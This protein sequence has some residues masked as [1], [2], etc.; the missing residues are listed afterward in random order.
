MIAFG[1]RG[2]VQP[3]VALGKSLKAEGH[4]VRIL[5]GAN[6]KDWI[7]RH[8]LEAVA[9][10]IDIQSLM[11]SDLGRD[12]IEKGANP[13]SQVSILKKLTEQTGW[14]AMIDAWSACR[15]TEVIFSSFTS[16]IYALSIAE[17]LGARHISM[18]LQPALFPTRSG[19][20][21]MNAPL[22]DRT[23]IINYV[24]GKLILEPFNWRLSGKMVNRFRREVLSLEPQTRAQFLAAKRRLFTLQAYSRHIVPHAEDWPSTVRTTGYWFLEEQ[25]EWEPPPDLARFLETG[26]PPV[27]IGF[28]SMIGRNLEQMTRIVIDAVR[29]GGRRAVLLSGWAGIGNGELGDKIYRLDAAPHEWLYPRVAAAVHHGGAGSTASSLRAGAPTVI[30]PHLGDQPFWGRRVHALG[31]GPAPIPRNKLTAS[32][33]AAAIRAATS[34]QSIKRRAEDL[35]SKI[36]SECGIGRAVELIDHYLR[37]S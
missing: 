36:R 13:I 6:F 26:Q 16:D 22:P 1:T 33:L 18:P 12:W 28:G 27:C 25:G 14:Q 10:K 20:A 24:F 37:A 23:S 17:K 19:A 9:A 32:K 21:T 15:D 35:G 31:A 5:A 34:D 30:V 7:E 2:D 29:E 3:A 8:G 11:E 4:S